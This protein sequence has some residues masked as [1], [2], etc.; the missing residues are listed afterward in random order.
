MVVELY[1]DGV[2]AVVP[3]DF[4]SDFR[5]SPDRG[6]ECVDIGFGFLTGDTRPL[7]FDRCLKLCE[8]GIG[9]TD[10]PGL[11]VT[12][13]GDAAIVPQGDIVA[14]PECDQSLTHTPA[15]G[16]FFVGTVHALHHGA[17]RQEHRANSPNLQLDAY[18]WVT[19]VTHLNVSATL[20]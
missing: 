11:G 19:Y 1:G 10:I 8:Y 13:S 14:F 12:K 5:V 17:P 9:H 7:P 4:G 3:D 2:G 18:A 6:K 20:T 15:S 16:I